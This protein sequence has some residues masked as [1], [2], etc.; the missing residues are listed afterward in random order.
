MTKPHQTLLLYPSLV[1][2]SAALASTA[3]AQQARRPAAAPAANAENDALVANAEADSYAIAEQLYAHAQTKGMD[4]ASRAAIMNRSAEL[5]GDFI[6]KYPN[7]ENHD[8]AQYLQAICQAE[9]GNHKASNANLANLANTRHGEYPAAA[10]YKLGTQAM[11]RSL[12][13]TAVGYFRIAVRETQRPGLR[14]DA[15]YRLGRSLLQMGNRPEAENSFRQ[16]QA[17]QG[18]QPA[19][20]QA[21]VLALAQMKTEDGADGEAYPLYRSLLDFPNLDARVRGTATLQAAR[22]ASRL[23]KSDEAQELY[24]RLATMP[25]MDKY[26]GEAQMETILNLYRNKDFEGIVRQV[27]GGY[28]QIDDPAMAARR[29]LI[30]G[31]ANMELRRYDSAAQWFALAEQA[32]PHSAIAADAGYRRIVCAQ[33]L[34][35]SSFLTLAE[36]YLAAYAQPGSATAELPNNELVRLMY[37]DKLMQAGLA[38]TGHEGQSPASS[39][40]ERKAQQENIAQASRQFDALNIDRLPEAVQ[41]DALYKKAWCGAQVDGE[42]PSDELMKT[43]ETFITRFTQDARLPEALVLRASCRTKRNEHGPALADYDRVINEFADSAAF[44]VACQRA[45][46]ACTGKDVA[47]MIGYYEKLIACGSPRVKPSAIAEAHY[48][49]A[50]A[51]YETEPARAIPHFEEASK[52]DAE[53]YSK[54]VD[55]GLVQCHYK[56]KD[57]EK[58]H[59]ALRKLE[60][61]NPASYQGLPP[62]I[63]RWCGWMCSQSRKFVDANKYLSD[64]LQREPQETYAAADGSQKTRAKVEPLVWKTLARV[65]LELKQYEFG[66]EPAQHYVSMETQPYR[67][68]D[69][70]RDEAQL[71]IGLGRTEEARKVCEEA[72]AL[73]IDGPLKSSVFITLGDAYY[74]EKQYSEAAKYYG[75]TANVVN[76]KELK[77]QALYKIARALR[78]AGKEGEA[79]QYEESLR[80]EFPGWNPSSAD[81]ALIEERPL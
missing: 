53:H 34:R 10:A 5:F 24:Q 81:V 59:A 8:K 9:A 42:R 15:T 11:S 76:D 63:L 47:K 1:A 60:A 79:A 46:Q 65:R 2:L 72:I 4:P 30:V 20:A 32:Q 51:L 14:S 69:G 57:A 74:V 73:G 12:W 33:Q 41:A 75:R 77:P 54:L 23:G 71:L 50:R 61:N 52:M 26:A 49:I 22:L 56:L 45:A 78:K 3:D 40:A 27:S 39:E 35:S 55:L 48:S 18:V 7:N 36:K 80:R 44:P 25:G 66:L 21:A 19:I 28:A 67:K 68:A 13:E 64:A 43:L 37:A 16:V 58:L 62:A 6:K 29:A 38:R 31:Q 70:M 17:M